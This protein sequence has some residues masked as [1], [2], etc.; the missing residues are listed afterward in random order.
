MAAAFENKT[1]AEIRDLLVNSFQEKFN[2]AFR[3]LPKS[4]IRVIATIF[5]GVYITLYKQIGW[6][7]LQLYPDTAYWGEVNI[8]G[9]RIRPL[10]KWGILIGVGEPRT[11]SQWQG[12]I[13]IRVLHQ[14]SSLIAGTQ[15]K[16]E[17]TG[18]LYITEEGAALE[19]D[20]ATA[21]VICAENG[22][23]GNLEAGDSL[24]FVSPLGTVERIAAVA[25]TTVYAME[26]EGEAEYRARVVNRFRNPP[27][28]GALA[29]YRRW[30]GD[31]PGVLNTYPYKDTQSPS[32]VLLYVSGTPSL[33]PNRIPSADLLKQVGEAC[34]Y[35]PQTGK[36]TRKPITAVID[37]SGNGSYQ[38]VKPVTVTKFDIYI[39]GIAGALLDDFADA[40]RP[41]IENYFLGREPYIRGLSDDNN[42]TRLISRNSISSAI[43]QAAAPLKAEFSGVTLQKTGGASINSY[44]LGVGELSSLGKLYLNGALYG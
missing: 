42:I 41:V 10:V 13:T 5:A 19:N 11:G 36:A 43:D 26:D 2:V 18:K 37:P 27:L 32:G 1:I 3:L 14:G 8:L 24:S 6:L 35:D 38:N 9:R 12:V 39:T 31:V 22:T 28:G 34:S 21:A 25:E 33:F 23:A 20:T 4:F 7:F 30:A 17:I 40:V 44:T 16:S 29:D 15:L